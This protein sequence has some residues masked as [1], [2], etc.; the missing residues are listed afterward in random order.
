MAKGAL[1]E[2]MRNHELNGLGRSNRAKFLA[3]DSFVAVKDYGKMVRRIPGLLDPKTGGRVLLCLNALE[4]G[5]S[6]LTDVVAKEAP[7]LELVGR[8]ENPDGF[9][10]DDNDR[11]LKVFVYRL[12]P[13]GQGGVRN[14]PQK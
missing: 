10:A 7:Q 9:A 5:A 8:L 14:V 3:H 4:L 1:R 11:A 13:S 6:V 12:G 2:G